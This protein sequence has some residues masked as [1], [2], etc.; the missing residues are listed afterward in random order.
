MDY[1][2]LDKVI[3]QLVRETE[4]HTEFGRIYT[5]ISST[6][7]RLPFHFLSPFFVLRVSFFFSKHCRDIYGLN[8]DEIEYVWKEY[9]ETIIDK[10]NNG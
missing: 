4:I 3:D 6:P 9:R 5:P 1:K 8:D 2:F 10:I 7:S